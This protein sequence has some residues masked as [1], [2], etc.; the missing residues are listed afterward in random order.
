MTEIELAKLVFSYLPSVGI[1][2][3]IAKLYMRISKFI[4]TI[5]NQ[6]TANRT[7]IDT[8]IKIHIERHDEDAKK[9]L[10]R[11]MP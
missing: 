2:L 4:E 10:H 6:V 5:E 11:K 9:F 1:V 3:G 7:D 8:L